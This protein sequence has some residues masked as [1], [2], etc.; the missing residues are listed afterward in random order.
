MKQQTHSIIPRN[1]V[2][3][4]MMYDAPLKQGSVGSN[5]T[6]QLSRGDDTLSTTDWSGS[7]F[8]D[9]LSLS[10]PNDS[11]VRFDLD[12]NVYIPIKAIED[13]KDYERRAAWYDRDSY[14]IMT[15][16]NNLTVK[17]MKIGREN[18]ESF[19]HCY[20]GLEHRTADMRQQREDNMKRAYQT[21][22]D[23]QSRQQE[24]NGVIVD[25][26]TIAKA[27]RLCTFSSLESAIALA[28]SD[29]Q[30][31]AAYHKEYASHIPPVAPK[32][33]S[34]HPTPQEE[35][36]PT[37]ASLSEG[38]ASSFDIK[39]ADLDDDNVSVLSD[40]EGSNDF[41]LYA[42]EGL[43]LVKRFKS[44]VQKRRSSIE[45]RGSSSKSSVSSSSRSSRRSGSFFR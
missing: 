9:S 2:L 23:E 24:Q 33:E 38:A 28:E 12:R 4:D 15:G 30:D 35:Q 36:T 34:V 29:A 32:Q 42:S 13:L 17:L 1:E 19:G 37:L 7:S 39:V 6:K 3:V 22:F 20:R 44:F 5:Y 41:T 25:P 10:F 8:T 43:G 14:N 16:A 21:V 26:R 11:T 27:Y 45:S 18:P 40:E 31:A